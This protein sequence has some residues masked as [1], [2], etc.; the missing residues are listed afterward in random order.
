MT[1]L[2]LKR[3][4][5][6][7]A[8]GEQKRIRV[9]GGT[10]VSLRRCWMVFISIDLHLDFPTLLRIHPSI[11][12]SGAEATILQFLTSAYFTPK[13]YMYV[14]RELPVPLACYRSVW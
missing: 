6:T 3:L 5:P 7:P 14:Q 4:I 1:A 12:E 8:T 10:Q 9:F 11:V 2:V 13:R